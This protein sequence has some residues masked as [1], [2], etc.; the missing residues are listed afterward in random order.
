MSEYLFQTVLEQRALRMRWLQ[1]H[2]NL[3]TAAAHPSQQWSGQQAP[4]IDRVEV[5]FKAQMVDDN[6]RTFEGLS[7]VWGMDLGDDVMHK[8][9]FKET[10]AAWKKSSDSLP[11]LNS[12]NHF[13]IMSVIGQLIDAKE[14]D[15]GLWSK[16]EVIPGAD[17]DAV[18]ARLRPSARTG[19]AAL[20]KMSIGFEP[21]KFDMEESEKARWGVI[22]N[23]R[24]VNLKEVSLVIFPMAPGARID[25]QTVKSFAPAA[26]SFLTILNGIE[27]I[28]DPE[29]KLIVRRILSRAGR[30]MKGESE[31]PTA[32][33]PIQAP[34]AD[35]PPVVP[36]PPAPP[37][38]TP[39]PTHPP[40]EPTPPAP[41]RAENEGTE[42]KDEQ[43]YLYAEA[44]QQRIRRIQLHNLTHRTGD[45]Q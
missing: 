15:E 3:K 6:A 35:V 33:T 45:I 22:R 21:A 36:A 39:T 41:V 1:R 28:D 27:R 16:W 30:L 32:P 24:K 12:H 13:D 11:L 40:T 29:A 17:G 42:A 38:P 4:T 37:V 9:A 8:G 18:L 44:L 10:I 14:T 43:P 23:L 19:R 7:S 20:Q 25:V 2:G 34:P 31:P 26:E 5:E